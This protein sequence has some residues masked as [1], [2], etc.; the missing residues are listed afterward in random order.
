M[1]STES[2]SR[3]YFS[4]LSVLGVVVL[5]G[6]PVWWKTTEVYRCPLPYEEI[7]GLR[8]Q[9]VPPVRAL[10]V[11]V[12]QL[13][14]SV[15]ELDDMVQQMQRELVDGSVSASNVRIRTH[16][17]VKPRQL[18]STDKEKL[19]SA[20]QSNTM[21]DFSAEVAKLLPSQL[22]HYTLVLVDSG[23]VEN[24]P[25]GKELSHGYVSHYRHALVLNKN[26][27]F[28][29]SLPTALKIVRGIYGD[30]K[31]LEK[32][33]KSTAGLQQERVD[34]ES[35][36]QLR[37]AQGYQISFTLLNPNPSEVE[38]TWNI[39]EATQQ[40]L[41]PFLEHPGVAS[42]GKYSISSQVFYYTDVK[43]KSRKNKAGLGYHILSSQL[44]P[45]I[46]SIES[47]LGSLVS[48]LP[49]LHFLVYIPKLSE[50]PLSI[51][52]SSKSDQHTDTF[53]IPQWG[54]VVFYNHGNVTS[55][56]DI[57]DVR[58]E[59]VMPVFVK[60]LKLLL[61]IPSELPPISDVK[62]SNGPLGITD[63]QADHVLIAKMVE[64]VSMA[65]TTLISLVSLLD[66]VKNM[67]ISD[68]IQAEVESSLNSIKQCYQMSAEGDLDAAYTLAKQAM[69]SAET[70]FFDPSILELLYFPDDQ[71]FA[72]Y[73]PLFLPISV[74]ILFS[75]IAAIKWLKTLRT[76][77][78][79]KLKS[80]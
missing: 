31:Q 69:D 27:D 44:P 78:A 39:E 47:K 61:G 20:L 16:Y 67:V 24:R 75:S 43:F 21:E 59:R 50:S 58:M 35:M 49:S 10:T 45:M 70:A 2:S 6:V 71:K 60:Q 57:V 54:G 22:G 36:R 53:L 11:W 38:T 55:D 56:P 74:P 42:L 19:M 7:V 5:V 73:I 13:S 26:K 29:D 37:A 51:L 68:H 76:N 41:M 80:D 72:I 3:Q 66:K 63:W 33:L 1:V 25:I 48:Q 52:P 8:A 18:G 28:S 40:V 77:S 17:V 30:R 14:S 9:Q 64:S 79:Q 32:T 12:T 46:S 15:R 34:L 65:S 4:A 23:L 62:L